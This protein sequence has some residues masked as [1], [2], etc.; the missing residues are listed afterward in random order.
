MARICSLTI[1]PVNIPLSV[2]FG[3][4]GGAQA[5]AANVIVELTLDDGTRGLGEAAPFPAVDGETQSIAVAALRRAEPLLMDVGADRVRLIA[6]RLAEALPESPS[7]R[8]ALE[9]ALLDALARRAGLSLWHWFGGFEPSLQ[10]DITI[11]TGDVDAAASAARRAVADGFHTLKIKLGGVPHDVDRD[12]LRAVAAAAPNAQLLLD[13]NQALDADAACALLDELGNSRERVVLYEQPVPA[14]DHDG[15]RWVRERGRVPVAADES[16]RS[17]ADVHR[18]AVARAADVINV[19]I[20]KTGV[21][22]ALDMIAA[23]R[24]A[25]LGLMMGGM[26][27]SALCMTT[28]ACLAAGQGGFSH[29]DLDTFLFLKDSPLTGGLA[30]KGDVLSVDAIARGHGVDWAARPK[31]AESG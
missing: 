6:S 29:V 13:A 11:V 1:T 19:K 23:A 20:T 15:L 27:E 2:P 25:G 26:V 18:L 28:S 21:V 17:A 7:A 14:A 3:I 31:S 12:R 4:A 24:A 8:C 22:E 9:T 16:A 30:R 10:T 5:V